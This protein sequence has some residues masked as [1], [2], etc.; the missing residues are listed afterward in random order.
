MRIQALKLP[1][2]S[3]YKRAQSYQQSAYNPL[4]AASFTP[5]SLTLSQ[6]QTDPDLSPRGSIWGRSDVRLGLTMAAGATVG[7]GIGALV[8]RSAGYS[9]GSSVAI[10]AGLGAVLPMAILYLGMAMWDGN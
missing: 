2:Y 1:L 10:G 5:D 6:S 7:G 9:L 4:K 8:S 3:Q